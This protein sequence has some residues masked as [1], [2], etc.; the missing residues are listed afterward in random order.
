MLKFRKNTCVGDAHIL[1]YDSKNFCVLTTKRSIFDRSTN[2]AFPG[3]ECTVLTLLALHNSNLL[4]AYVLVN[5][6]LTMGSVLPIRLYN[7]KSCRFH[8]SHVAVAFS[9]QCR[10]MNMFQTL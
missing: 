2:I 7:R 5:G 1:L 10:H 9:Y 6:K 8:G 3:H 4:G